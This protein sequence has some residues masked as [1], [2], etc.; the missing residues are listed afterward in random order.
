MVK[1]KFLVFILSFGTLLS[2]NGQD[3]ADSTTLLLSLRDAQN[4]AL[5]HNRTLMNASLDVRK[6]EANRWTSIATMLPQVNG[7]LDYSNYMGYKMELG[8][9]SIAMPPYGSLGITS[10]I[11]LSGAQI[12]S[13]QL[14]TIA[15]K[16]SDITLKKTEQEIIET[17]KLL[18]FS[19]LVSQETISLLE[20][21][22]E[23][24]KKLY[25]FSKKSV[26][27]GVSEKIDAD[28]ILVQ[29][30][31]MQTSLSSA[32]RSLEMIFNSL[33][34]QLNIDFDKEIVLSQGIAEL[35]DSDVSLSLLS[36][37]FSVDNNYDYQLVKENTNLIKKQMQLAGWAYAPTLSAY[38]Q[39]TGKQY[40]SDENKM[41][42]TPPNMIGLKLS[43]PI[44]SSG[45]TY[46]TL[47][48]AQLEYKK[49]L[50]KLEDAEM[51]LK[52]KHRQLKYNLT[53]AYER[54]ITQKKSV[55]VSQSVFDN[56]GKKYEFGMS[57]SLDVT[58]SGTNLIN[59]QSAYVQASY[60]FVSAQV[61]L[62]KLL[63]INIRK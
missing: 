8:S 63:N 48:G 35:F 5:E 25:D 47:R 29:V 40:F 28:Q 45:K 15:M 12:I 22:L 36:D 21:N 13:S 38:H 53:S 20:K 18:Y 34:L 37:E 23:S 62:E 60:D 14:G 42:M 1:R 31:S 46:N 61:E 52:I 3:V 16:M 44:F 27:V 43:V 30:S 41:N 50:N 24:I 59:A 17:V 11:A 10:S 9:M 33:R 26:E 55:E 49:Q 39:F 32:K 54:Y 4:Y 19:A 51:S 7:T 58:T 56:I 6:A 2:A 57:S